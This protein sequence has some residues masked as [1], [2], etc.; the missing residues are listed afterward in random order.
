MVFEEMIN[1]YFFLMH[2]IQLIMCTQQVFCKRVCALGTRIL[3]SRLHVL[4]LFMYTVSVGLLVSIVVP[5]II[6]HPRGAQLFFAPMWARLNTRDTRRKNTSI[7]TR[8]IA[9]L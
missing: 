6:H 9:S 8:Y 2:Y 3:L 1:L 4:V 7:P 5:S